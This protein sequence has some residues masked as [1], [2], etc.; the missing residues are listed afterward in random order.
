[1]EKL[2]AIHHINMAIHAIAQ[3]HEFITLLGHLVK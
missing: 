2:L 3:A 1:M